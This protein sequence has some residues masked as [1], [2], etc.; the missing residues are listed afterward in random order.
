MRIGEGIPKICVPIVERT[1]EEILAAAVSILEEPFDLVEWRADFFND[2]QDPD[3]VEEVLRLLHKAL[4]N[5][6]VLFTFR[7]MR[8]GGER[9][10]STL[11]YVDLIETVA[12]TGLADLID[13]EVTM[14]E[15]AVAN[16]IDVV[17]AYGGIVVASCH[18][19]DRTPPARDIIAVLRKMQALDADIPKMAVMP[20]NKQ[21][22]LT[23]LAATEEMTRVYA[24][25]PVITMAMGVD[26]QISRVAGE[27][28]GSAVTFGAVGKTSAPG[29]LAA[30]DLS[31]ILQKLHTR[32]KE[33]IFLIGFMGAGKSAAGRALSRHAGAELIEMDAAIEREQEMKISDIF[34]QF[35]EAY[36]RDLET[37]FL[38]Q[39]PESGPLVVSCGG[40]V[41]LRENN[42]RLM[43]E[44][45]VVILL[46]A[47]PETVLARVGSSTHRPLLEGHMNVDDIQALMEQ[48]LPRY[49]EAADAVIATD[50]RTVA[51][52]AAD[53]ALRAQEL[54]A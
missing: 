43:K 42:V 9:E 14:G 47:N 31:D 29:Q 12:K 53:I 1:S 10:C 35:G 51:E 26:G 39:L 13:I 24:D 17:H 27:T 54:L 30:S 48:R 45:G 20:N 22:V 11:E 16:L 50:N 52:V 23:L 6:P 8:E 15:A 49:L 32:K 25:R 40:G 36:F 34:E 19:F 5:T 33:H 37:S 38:Q 41:A 18:T 7:T 2:I 28:F 44:Q 4:G 21:D 3:S 46:T